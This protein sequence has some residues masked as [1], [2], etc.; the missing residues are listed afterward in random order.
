MSSK[1]SVDPVNTTLV[2][3]FN[4]FKVL[5]EGEKIFDRHQRRKARQQ[6][7]KDREKQRQAALRR[8]EERRR[9]YLEAQKI[10]TEKQKQEA[11]RRRQYWESLSPEEKV[12][13]VKR[14][15]ELRARQNEM[16]AILFMGLIAASAEGDNS[17]NSPSTLDRQLHRR[18]TSPTRQRQPVR[19]L[20]CHHYSC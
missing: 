14:Q 3:G 15:E 8:R 19:K 17:S 4:P 16:I 2:A 10:A 6:R 5:R 20:P 7:D 9:A 18:T 1:S 12:A 11:E 13:Y